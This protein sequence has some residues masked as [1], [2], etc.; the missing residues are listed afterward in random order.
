MISNNDP[1]LA[2]ALT[3]KR[4][5]KQNDWPQKITDDWAK[6]LGVKHP[7]GPWAS[8]MCGAMKADGYN[9]KAEFFLS[10][11]TFNRFVFEQQLT[12][13]QDTKLRE[14]LSDAKALLLD[15]GEP[16]GGAEFWS[17]FAGLLQP[18]EA[19]ATQEQMTQEDCD[20]WVQIQRDN[21]RKVCLKNMCSRSEGW[22]LLL[23]AMHKACTEKGDTFPP[24]DSDWIQ[25][26][27]SGM[28]DPPLEEC[29]RRAHRADEKGSRPLQTAMEQ[30]LGEKESKKLSLIA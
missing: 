16:Y 11:G 7:H 4:W 27:L 5:F 2:F 3:L 26:V 13:V 10:L 25:E 28:H 9:P 12:S 1:A 23:E 21:F 15:N 30:L 18:P 20:L 29:L 17:L 24:D 8:Q 22:E 19:F 6:D 14:R